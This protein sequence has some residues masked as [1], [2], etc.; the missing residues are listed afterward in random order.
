L[1]FLVALAMSVYYT[2]ELLVYKQPLL[3]GIS[4]WPPVIIMSVMNAFAEEIMY[5]LTVMRLAV[6]AEYPAWVA[7]LLQSVLYSLIHFMVAGAMLGLFSL[8]YG[9]ILG[10]VAQRSKSILPA[11]IC[12]FIIDIGCIG[13]P[14]LRM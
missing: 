9:F 4:F 3:R 6:H 8:L 2:L 7:N 14:I 11:I 1:L 5:R 10:L 12:H 13:M